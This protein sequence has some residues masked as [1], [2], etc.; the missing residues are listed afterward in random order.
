MA[1][2]PQRSRAIGAGRTA[3]VQALVFHALPGGLF[4]VVSAVAALTVGPILYRVLG[5]RAAVLTAALSYSNLVFAGSAPLWSAAFRS[6]A[7]NRQC[8][9]P[10]VGG[11]RSSGNVTR[12]FAGTHLWLGPVAESRRCRRRSPRAAF[13]ARQA[14][15]CRHPPRSALSVEHPLIHARLRIKLSKPDNPGDG[16]YDER[17]VNLTFQCDTWQYMIISDTTWL[18]G[19]LVKQW[20]GD[21]DYIHIDPDKPLSEAAKALCSK[22]YGSV[23]TRK[24]VGG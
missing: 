4:G 15:L 23:Q 3:E 19:K 24:T 5:A 7:R 2:C 21:T 17:I 22:T 18:H 13:A 8:A 1:G 6:A 11:I 10:G 12:T 20:E 14:A 16:P 9:R